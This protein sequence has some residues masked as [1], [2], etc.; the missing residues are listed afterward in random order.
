MPTARQS[1]AL[2]G[3][4][5]P[6]VDDVAPPES[7]DLVER[8][9]DLVEAVV[10]TEVDPP[11]RARIAREVETLT[12]RLG[13]RTREPGVLFARL[14]NGEW[15]NLSNAGHGI[16]NPQAVRLEWVDPQPMAPPGADVTGLETHARCT[17]TEAHSGAHRRAHGGVVALILD[18]ATGRVAH[19]AGAGGLT[20]RLE[21]NFRRG[22]PL[23][24]P[25]EITARWIGRDGRKSYAEAEIYAE[26]VLA[27]TGNALM[28]IDPTPEAAE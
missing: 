8:V 10:L 12:A 14:P 1:L 4:Q 3:D 17:L 18:Q 25:L 13:A 11:E 24:V 27:A 19:F 7:R 23:G 21:V 16:L 20:A 9:R 6:P 5:L 28:V 2:L 15:E 22:T 26:G